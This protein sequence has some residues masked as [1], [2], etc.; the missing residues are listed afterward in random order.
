M[1]RTGWGQLVRWNPNSASDAKSSSAFKMDADVAARRNCFIGAETWLGGTYA[2]GDLWG[3]RGLG[4][5]GR[6]HD[7]SAEQ[8][9]TTVQDSLTQ[10]VWERSGFKAS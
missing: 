8:Y 1:F 5:S 10:R 3:Y 9:I 6:W 7:Q 4:F 2:K